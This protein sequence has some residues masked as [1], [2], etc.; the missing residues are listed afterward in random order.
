MVHMIMELVGNR[1]FTQGR[2]KKSVLQGVFHET[3]LFNSY[4]SN[5]PNTVSRKY[6]Y[7]DDLAIIHVDGDR[8]AVEGC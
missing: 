4:T 5:L 6:T 1:S 3:F 8:Q 2:L 7:A